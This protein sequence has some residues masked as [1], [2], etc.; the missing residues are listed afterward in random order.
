M[1]VQQ[2]TALFFHFIGVLHFQ[3]KQVPEDFFAD[4]ISGKNFLRPSLISLFENV[5]T[6]NAAC[7]ADALAKL[8]RRARNF[9]AYVEERFAIQFDVEDDDEENLPVY[10]TL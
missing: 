1:A 10:V 7:D 3:L 8:R 5:L 9:K 6:T 2:R 4:I